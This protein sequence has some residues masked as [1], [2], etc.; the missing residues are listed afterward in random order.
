MAQ[1]APRFTP[2]QILEAGHRA[3]AEGRTEYAIQF[4][5]HLMDH[6]PRAPEALLAREALQRLDPPRGASLNGAAAGA[7]NPPPPPPVPPPG[8]MPGLAESLAEAAPWPQPSMRGAPAGP[9]PKPAEPAPQRAALPPVIELPEPRR[10]YGLGRA[11]ARLL[12]GF[13]WLQIVAGLLATATGVLGLFVPEARITPPSV[14]GI[15]AIGSLTLLGLAIVVPGLL[16]VFI[17]QVSRAIFDGANA[18]RDLAQIA[19]A[20]A[21]AGR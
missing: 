7:A 20:R 17:G 10:D 4:F 18:S 19:R 15:G 11:M 14:P 2:A 16:F 5:R 9:P 21:A 3:E 12:S 8:A 13:G 1:T 6:H